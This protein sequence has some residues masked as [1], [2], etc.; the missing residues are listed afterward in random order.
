[1]ASEYEALR[2][3]MLRLPRGNTIDDTLAAKWERAYGHSA[4]IRS[5]IEQAR[6]ALGAL[7]RDPKDIRG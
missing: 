4:H 1:M 3:A 6:V 2:G 7:P 5:V